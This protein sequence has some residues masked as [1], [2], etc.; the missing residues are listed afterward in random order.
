MVHANICQANPAASQALAKAEQRAAA[1]ATQGA[2]WRPVSQAV[3]I[4]AILDWQCDLAWNA[5]A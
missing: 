3:M 2:V 4:L 1:E 5:A